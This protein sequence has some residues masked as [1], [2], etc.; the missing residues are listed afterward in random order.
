MANFLEPILKVTDG[1][2]INDDTFNFLNLSGR[3]AYYSQGYFG[4]GVTVAVVDTGI[5]ANHPE[6]SDGNVLPGKSFCYYPSTN[7]D[8]GH[9]T[10]VAATI[11]GKN[12]GIAPKARLLPIKALD[13]GGGNS[14]DN[15]IS[16]FEYLTTWR[17]EKGQPVDIVSASLSIP[18]N[19]MSPTQILRFRTV[20]KRL[21]DLDITIIVSAGNS[22]NSSAERYPSAY[23]EP[24]TVGAV[25]IN[26]NV[27]YFSTRTDAVDVCQ[28]GVDVVSADYNGGYVAMSG[29]SMATPIVSGIA[30]LIACKYKAMFGKRIPEMVTYET[31][32]LSTLDIDIPGVDKNTGAGFLSLNQ[33][34]AVS[35]VMTI[36][37]LDFY[38]NGKKH[39][40]D[41]APR[42]EDDRTLVPLRALSEILGATVEWNQQYK[43]IT[44]SR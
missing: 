9:G 13:G 24:I 2:V 3:K 39:I 36:G 33:M 34:P 23:E 4:Q 27:A 6:F 37:E 16:A 19:M 35:A 12:A 42:I 31:L 43:R 21:N 30:A 22:G 41:I 32:K 5:N 17:D 18:A 44:V 38:I 11:A 15:I 20:L 14:I 10:H 7:D 29:T 26:K 40:F 1:V 25:D 8:N 28:V